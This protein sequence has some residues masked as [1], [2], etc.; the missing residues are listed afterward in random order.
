[1]N[2]LVIGMFIKEFDY[3]FLIFSECKRMQWHHAV[4]ST[5]QC[6]D[7][8]IISSSFFS[9][10]HEIELYFC[11]IDVSV[12]VHHHGFGTTSVHDGE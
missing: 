4:N 6:F 1:M 3:L 2:D 8:I 5:T 10:Y 11:T 12:I 9:M 7:F